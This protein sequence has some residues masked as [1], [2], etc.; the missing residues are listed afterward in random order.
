MSAP[1]TK[2]L[3]PAN[4]HHRAHAVI[5]LGHVQAGVQPF[6]H[7]HPEGVDRRVLNGQDKDFAVSALVHKIFLLRCHLFSLCT[8]AR[9]ETRPNS[10]SVLAG[11]FR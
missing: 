2:V 7:P 3:P 9:S 10:A 1:A 4:D 8:A 11:W 6:R 5:T